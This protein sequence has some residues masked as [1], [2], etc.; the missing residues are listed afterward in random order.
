MYTC[1]CSH[2]AIILPSAARHAQATR[3]S[4]ATHHGYCINSY[5]WYEFNNYQ[6]NNLRRESSKNIKISLTL[7]HFSPDS[8]FEASSMSTRVHD[9]DPRRPWC[10][11][12]T[13]DVGIMISRQRCSEV[14]EQLDPFFATFREQPLLGGPRRGLSAKNWTMI[15]AP[16]LQHPFI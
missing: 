10:A 6:E 4:R 1:R 8:P 15:L 12:N 11:L 9:S 2:R 14:W 7:R 3:V 16:D 5:L 13:R